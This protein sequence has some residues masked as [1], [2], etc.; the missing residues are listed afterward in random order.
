MLIKVHSL[1]FIGYDEKGKP[2]NAIL[3]ANDDSY[4]LECNG[5]FSKVGFSCIN[6]DSNKLIICYD[7]IDGLKEWRQVK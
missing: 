6:D 2:A 3:Q 7:L 5:S 4:K 1:V